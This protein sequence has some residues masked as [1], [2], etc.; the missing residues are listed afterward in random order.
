MGPN[1]QVRGGKGGIAASEA[2]KRERELVWGLVG[3]SITGRGYTREVQ[4]G[5]TKM[6]PF[7]PRWVFC[8]ETSTGNRSHH[9]LPGWP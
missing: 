7:G 9:G 6:A 4:R 5:D 8:G 3:G 2:S 1:G